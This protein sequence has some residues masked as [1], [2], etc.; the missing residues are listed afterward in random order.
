MKTTSR[1]FT[2]AKPTKSDPNVLPSNLSTLW[3][4]QRQETLIN[5]VLQGR[6][7]LD[8][9]GA[10]CVSRRLLWKAAL[11]VAL[12]VGMSVLGKRTYAEMKSSHE[13]EARES[14][15]RDVKEM[16]LKPWFKNKGDEGFALEHDNEA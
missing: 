13:L 16:A 9:K 1:T 10:S 12:I 11:D 2:F 3:T 14:I 6:K 4:P 5:G 8:P 15:K 7:Q